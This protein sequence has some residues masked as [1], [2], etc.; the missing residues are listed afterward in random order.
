MK[1]ITSIETAVR[2]YTMHQTLT[3]KEIAELFGITTSAA[4][5]Y[6]NR[7]KRLQ[8]EAGIPLFEVHAVDTTFA[9]EKWGLDIKD[10]ERRYRKAVALG[11]VGKEVTT[12]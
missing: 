9:Y 10:L 11:F 1:H 3:S 4:R 12:S 2:I 7:I 8:I 6:L 5:Q